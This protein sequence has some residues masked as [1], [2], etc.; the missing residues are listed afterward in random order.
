[1]LLSEA[2][3]KF[4]EEKNKIRESKLEFEKQKES[5]EKKIEDLKERI[6][7]YKNESWFEEVIKEKE[8]YGVF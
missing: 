3:E 5:R 2:E 8:L 4:I 7:K 1:M 6:V